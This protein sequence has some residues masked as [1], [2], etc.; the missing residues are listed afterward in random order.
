MTV[1]TRAEAADFN[2]ETRKQKTGSC[3]YDYRGRR[4]LIIR[5]AAQ[6]VGRED[7]V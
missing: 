7:R 5:N 4:A 2:Q 3:N 1:E 6:D